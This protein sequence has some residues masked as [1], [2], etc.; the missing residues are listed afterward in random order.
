[1]W[2]RVP[3]VCLEIRGSRLADNGHSRWDAKAGVVDL[4]DPRFAHFQTDH[5]IVANA[6]AESGHVLDRVRVPHGESRVGRVAVIQANENGLY[7][8][9]PI[10]SLIH[11]R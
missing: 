8:P 3:I 11:P 10:R 9:Q 2:A 1:M 4:H 5:S 7:I 6:T